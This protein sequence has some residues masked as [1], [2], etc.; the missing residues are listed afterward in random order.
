MRKWPFAVLVSIIV[1]LAVLYYAGFFTP[2]T[3]GPPPFASDP[4]DI[5][6]KLD[7]TES[8]YER[9]TGVLHVPNVAASTLTVNDTLY[10]KLDFLGAGATSEVG[11]PEIPFLAYYFVLP[12]DAQGNAPAPIANLEVKETVDHKD[13]KVYPAQPPAPENV[14]AEIPPFTIDEQAYMS[15][16]PYPGKLHEERTAKIGDIDLLILRVYPIQY[17][18][19]DRLV[20]LRKTINIDLDFDPQHAAVSPAMMISDWRYAPAIPHIENND[21]IQMMPVTLAAYPLQVFDDPLYSLLIITHQDLFGAAYR[22]AQHKRDLGWKVKLVAAADIQPGG[23]YNPTLDEAIKAF[24]RDEWERNR[25]MSTRMDPNEPGITDDKD[26]MAFNFIRKQDEFYAEVFLRSTLTL[27]PLIYIHVDLDG[28]GVADRTISI[29]WQQFEVR[30]GTTVLTNGTALVKD[31]MVSIHFPWLAAFPASAPDATA[32]AVCELNDRAP[33]EG[34]APL[35]WEGGLHTLRYLLLMGDADR[36]RP[37]FGVNEGLVELSASRPKALGVG[38]DLYYAIVQDKAD[39]YPDLSIGRIP[40]DNATQADDVVDKIIAYET[41]TAPAAFQ[42]TFAVAGAFYDLRAYKPTTEA[43]GTVDGF[44]YLTQGSRDV[45]G[46]GS[47]FTH[48]VREGDWIRIWGSGADFVQVA[49]VTDG[50][51]LTLVEPW[52]PAGTVG[53]FEVWRVDGRDDA[54]FIK[55]A[56]RVRRYL[57]DELGYSAD[58]YYRTDWEHSNPRFLADGTELPA[59]LQRP[60]YGWDASTAD[61]LGEL[62]TGENLFILHRDHGEFSGWGE[63]GLKTWDITAGAHAATALLPVVFSIN[64]ASGYFDNEYDYWLLRQPDGSFL[65][66]PASPANG[67]DW[68]ADDNLNFAEALLRQ[69]DGGAI[70]IIA[71]TRLSYSGNNDIFTDGIFSYMYSGYVGLES[72]TIFVGGSRALGDIHHYAKL[73][74]GARI[75]DDRWLLYYMEIFHVI[76]DPT[77]Q[78][79]FAA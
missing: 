8:T 1:L 67:A 57:V 71:P 18:P 16:S 38:T 76:G 32:W 36:I 25:L 44:I 74:A 55:T 40:V 9:W 43:G 42:R 10:H 46:A 39:P 29:W 72:G 21:T 51:H 63:P 47:W 14:G 7:A 4:R 33:D 70:G 60:A 17:I 12:H 73:Y 53:T 11:K 78:V 52:A 6:L 2:K 66:T 58:I 20:Q 48:D 19:G 28:N 56:E 65:R 26:I 15:M 59:G 24:V 30:E 13:V 45:T 5:T 34:S 37:N 68:S 41:A 61:V 49:S 3:E 22:L 35:N 77:L 64:C 62:N 69:P 54:V 31:N 79:K 75:E 23:Y 27:S 50:Q